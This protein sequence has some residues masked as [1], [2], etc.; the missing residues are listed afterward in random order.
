MELSFWNKSKY[1]NWRFAL[2]KNNHITFG[3]FNNSPKISKDVIKVWSQVLTKI[4]HSKLIIKAPSNDSEIAQ[5]NILKNF[6]YFNIDSSKI[7]FYQREKI[8]N[9]HLKLYNKIDV[10]LDT[11]PYPGVTTSMESIWMGV[12]VLTLEG[13]NFVSRCGE[14][15]NLNL[16][17]PEFIAKNKNDYIN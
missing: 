1:R 10:T 15:I 17:M 11:F 5:L 9:D 2:L 12:P 16:N 3:C 13:N 8:R 7:I 6:K 14:S 4:K